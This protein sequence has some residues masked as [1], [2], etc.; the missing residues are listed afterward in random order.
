MSTSVI[1]RLRV[2]SIESWQAVY[3]QTIGLRERYGCLFDDI[4]PSPLDGVESDGTTVVLMQVFPSPTLAK[5]FLHDPDLGLAMAWGGVLDDPVV[6]LLAE[7]QPRLW[8]FD[9]RRLPPC[10]GARDHTFG[11]DSRGCA[12]TRRT[13]RH[14]GGALHDAFRRSGSVPFDRCI[15]HR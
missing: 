5:A 8:E 1:I 10:A 13:R 9:D 11:T 15:R 7:D 14:D 3:T 12:S 4:L 6:H 2:R